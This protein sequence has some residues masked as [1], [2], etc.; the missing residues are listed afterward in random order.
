[1]HRLMIIS[2]SSLV[3]IVGLLFWLYAIDMIGLVILALASTGAIVAI[4]LIHIIFI[5]KQKIPREDP[6]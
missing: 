5:I 3:I 1:M 2:Y 4:T 6:Q